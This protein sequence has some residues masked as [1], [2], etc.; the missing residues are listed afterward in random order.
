LPSAVAFFAEIAN[1]SK[2]GAGLL[3]AEPSGQV[4]PPRFERELQAALQ[5]GFQ[6]VDRPAIHGCSAAFLRKG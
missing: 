4:K 5:A 2:P 6:L 1:A 3:F